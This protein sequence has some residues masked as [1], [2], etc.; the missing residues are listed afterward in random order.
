LEHPYQLYTKTCRLNAI[1]P[2]K[3]S[4]FASVH[5]TNDT[6]VFYRECRSLAKLYDVTLIGI[7]N[8][9][10]QKDGVNIIGIPKPKSRI[11]RLV[12][13]TFIVFFKAFK[14]NAR[15]Y[16]IHD[17]ELLPFGIMLSLLGKKVIYDI[18]ENTYQDI[19]HKPW[20]PGPIK[21][22]ISRSYKLLECISSYFMHFIIVAAKPE[23][24]A[25]FC[26]R[27][28]T[29]IQNFADTDELKPFRIASRSSIS[30]NTLIYMG[31]I[32]DMYYNFNVLADAI[33]IL[34]N[35][36]ISIKLHVVGY[37]KNYLEKEWQLHPQY[38]ILKDYIHFTGHQ[39][40]VYAYEISQQCKM[41][42]CLKNQPENILVSHERKFFEYM[43]LGLPFICCD[44]QI[45]KEALHTF[46]CGMAVNL[47]DANSIAQAIKQMLYEAKLLDTM[48]T[49]AINASEKMYNWH[50]QE[51]IL[52]ELYQRM[53][54]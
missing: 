44:S 42:I 47:K 54:N 36:N 26:K 19:R 10:G 29:I 20:I 24:T 7:G 43:A 5:T 45:Y 33:A 28:Y 3:I 4:H 46:N 37:A 34:L 32:Q 16:H 39:S 17:A 30:E 31:T 14:I 48:A 51:K 13:T 21:W 18:H 38:S 49:E 6:R 27:K 12:F 9:T 53:I 2:I 8:F 25:Q 41:A 15:V 1:N 11:H 35:Q 40:P 50:S 52:L 22:V 23:L